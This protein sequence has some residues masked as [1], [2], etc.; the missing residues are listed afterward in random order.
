MERDFKD[1]LSA[2][3]DEEVEYLLVLARENEPIKV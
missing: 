2:F 1:M 3:S